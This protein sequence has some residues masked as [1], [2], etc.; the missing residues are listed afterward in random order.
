[1]GLFEIPLKITT[2]SSLVLASAVHS[3]SI[4]TSFLAY[5][6]GLQHR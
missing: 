6:L 2:S 1:M 4:S 5:P 3:A